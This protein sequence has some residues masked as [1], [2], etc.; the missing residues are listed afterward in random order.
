MS[1]VW[2][3]SAACCLLVMVIF[4]SCLAM[5]T[6]GDFINEFTAS[7]RGGDKEVKEV[8][9]HLE[10]REAV[11]VMRTVSNLKSININHI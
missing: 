7:V 11:H 6:P 9:R 2:T 10:K 1:M 4:T 8:L 3:P 5:D